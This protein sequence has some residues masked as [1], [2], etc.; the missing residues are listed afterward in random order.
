MTKTYLIKRKWWEIGSFIFGKLGK[1]RTRPSTYIQS[2]K[3][4]K[5]EFHPLSSR[6]TE[7][8]HAK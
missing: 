5:Y 3:A 2:K 6:E 4:F 8:T 1:D 7:L